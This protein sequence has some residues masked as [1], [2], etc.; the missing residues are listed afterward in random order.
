LTSSVPNVPQVEYQ[1]LGMTLKTT[2]NVMRNSEVALTIDMKV[3][4]LSGTSINGNPVLSNQAYSGVI[5]LKQGEGAVLISD[6]NKQESRA[7]SGVPG[8]SEI[9]GLNN[10]TGN[11]TQKSFAKLLIVITPH[12]IRG[13]QAAGHSP[14]MWVER[15][16]PA[17]AR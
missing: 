17:A 12:V 16:Q 14:K 5:T 4:A 7:I 13:T 2:A 15:S 3:V 11:D 6:L 9:P 8:L 1:D 10:L